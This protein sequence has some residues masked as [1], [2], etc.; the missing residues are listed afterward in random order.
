MYLPNGTAGE[1]W[2]ARNCNGCVHDTDPGDD[3]GCPIMAFSVLFNYDQIPPPTEAV[4]QASREAHTPNALTR[5]ERHRRL[6]KWAEY[7]RKVAK[8]EVAEF[9]LE[10]VAPRSVPGEPCRMRVP[11]AKVIG[12]REVPRG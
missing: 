9:L 12:A 5:D 11:V 6:G 4:E 8:A 2:M 1:M 7:V 10:T 3:G